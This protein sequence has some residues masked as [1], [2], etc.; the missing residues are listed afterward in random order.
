MV[1]YPEMANHIQDQ[2]YYEKSLLDT[3]RSTTPT[4]MPIIKIIVHTA[5]PIAREQLSVKKRSNVLGHCGRC[6]FLWI[7]TDIHKIFE[8]ENATTR[9]EKQSVSDSI[10][11]F[12]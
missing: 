6:G 5:A 11:L 7:K 4:E 8:P 2:S 12:L 3:S 10:V 1:L 9:Q